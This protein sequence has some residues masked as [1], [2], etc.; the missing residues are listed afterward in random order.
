MPSAYWQIYPFLILMQTIDKNVKLDRAKKRT[1]A[2]KLQVNRNP[3]IGILWMA[4]NQLV[5]INFTT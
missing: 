2:S 3:L 5:W 1:F 4:F